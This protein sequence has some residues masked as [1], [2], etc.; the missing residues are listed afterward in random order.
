MKKIL[1][2]FL[3]IIT[4]NFA[5][6]QMEFSDNTAGQKINWASYNK[7]L[8][9]TLINVNYDGN[10]YLYDSF[11][12]GKI[13]PIAGVFPIRYQ[14]VDDIMQVQ[15]SKDSVLLIDKKNTNYKININNKIFQSYQYNNDYFYFNVLT[16]NK[17]YNL[18]KRSYKK[19]IAEKKPVNSY[20]TS[21]KAYFTETKTEYFLYLN[22]EK[23]IVELPTKERKL[24]KLFPHLKEKIKS[25]IDNKKIDITNNNDLIKLINFIDK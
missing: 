17:K 2:L 24:L 10:P 4:T 21:K 14:I 13:N 25:F 11:I 19:F 9:K 22:D 23:K 7:S 8:E 5:Y 12:I 3:L 16:N 15:T 18:L 1:K 6:G 20:S